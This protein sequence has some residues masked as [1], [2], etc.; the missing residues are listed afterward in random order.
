M[1]KFRISTIFQ[2]VY[3]SKPYVCVASSLQH[4]RKYYNILIHESVMKASY[5]KK[6]RKSLYFFGYPRYKISELSKY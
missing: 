6:C 3:V 4:F 2:S 5:L 1:K